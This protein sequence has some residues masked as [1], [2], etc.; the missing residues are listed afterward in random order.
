MKL[1]QLFA[2]ITGKTNMF[3]F[4][5]VEFH[6]EYG[7]FA[8]ISR[9]RKLCFA[10]VN[11]GFVLIGG[12]WVVSSIC[13][14]GPYFIKHRSNA[15]LTFYLIDAVMYIFQNV[16][17]TTKNVCG[18][19]VLLCILNKMLQLDNRMQT[20]LFYRPNIR[21]VYM[22]YRKVMC[23]VVIYY[24]CVNNTVSLW[25]RNSSTNS[26]TYFFEILYTIMLLQSNCFLILCIT[27]AMVLRSQF[28]FLDKVIGKCVESNLSKGFHNK[29]HHILME[30]FTCY[31]QA[32]V[33]VRKFGN[34]FGVYFIFLAMIVVSEATML[35]FHLW[36]IETV[37]EYFCS[38]CSAVLI[39]VGSIGWLIAQTICLLTVI[40]LLGRIR[41]QV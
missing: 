38:E 10:G 22:V 35:W 29:T 36:E 19:E 9:G 12:A 16:L 11:A 20:H 17:M 34:A 13:R 14:N 26:F 41:N 8:T 2:T 15:I 39:A 25:G 30:C 7:Q 32:L 37:Q 24:V 28:T 1:H 4:T 40:L 3:G 23:I 33:I 6:P 27:C 21:K 31:D 18:S 5:A